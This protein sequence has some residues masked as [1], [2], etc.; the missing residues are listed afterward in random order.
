MELDVVPGSYKLFYL[1][2]LSQ[3][4]P[5]RKFRHRDWFL[6]LVIGLRNGDRYI[7]LIKSRNLIVVGRCRIGFVGS[8][9]RQVKVQHLRPF[10]DQNALPRQGNSRRCRRAD[11]GNENAFPDGGALGGFY[12]LNVEHE[13]GEA[14][15]ENAGLHFERRLRGFEPILKTSECGLGCG[16]KVHGV[17]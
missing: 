8:A 5:G 7:G 3:Q 13:L 17:E 10:A 12:V 14:L 16:R 1:A 2:C 4:F 15:V 6:I 11:V 9:I